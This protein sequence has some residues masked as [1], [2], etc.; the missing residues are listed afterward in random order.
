MQMVIPCRPVTRVAFIAVLAALAGC[1]TSGSSVAAAGKA[2][3]AATA[4]AAPSTASASTPTAVATTP[5]AA[6]TAS[7]LLD[8]ALSAMLAEKSA[9]IDCTVSS[10]AGE[11]AES[12][13]IGVTSGRIA[14]TGGSVSITA[15]LVGGVA[16]MTINTPGVLAAQG[17]PEA[18]AEKLAGEW[19]SIRPGESYGHVDLNY[20]TAVHGMTL[21]SQADALRVT[22]TL[23]RTGAT[24]ARGVAVYAVSGDTTPYYSGTPSGA[25]GAAETVYIAA[26]G[27]PLPVSV[28]ARS[29][30]GTTTTCTYSSW[31]RPLKL[32]APAHAV[33]LTA[34]PA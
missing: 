29:G 9:H 30:S 33:P 24:R 17:V 7:T 34:I 21:A 4:S 26:S 15:L 32:T 5:R 25:N 6:Q 11:D 12:E 13:D 20:A 19:I 14:S 16:Y 10:S 22:G 27:A 23:K 8:S 1:S 18:E 2:S 28:T 31:G 3:T